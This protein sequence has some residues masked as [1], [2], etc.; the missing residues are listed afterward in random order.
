MCGVCA[1][2]GLFDGM[3]GGGVCACGGLFDGSIVKPRAVF[4]G[5]F[6]CVYVLDVCSVHSVCVLVP[7]ILHFSKQELATLSLC[8]HHSE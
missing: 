3:R 8:L 5:K 7:L 4:Q 6:V 1:C 2:G